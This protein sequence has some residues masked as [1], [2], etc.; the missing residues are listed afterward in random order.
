MATTVDRPTIT[1]LDQPCCTPP[2]TPTVTEPEAETYAAWFKAL[3]NRSTGIV[4]AGAGAATELI[5]VLL[6]A[7]ADRKKFPW[8]AA[9]PVRTMFPTYA[10]CVLTT[11]RGHTMWCS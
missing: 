9:S 8:P 3:A 1:I 5:T 11:R 4:S 10:W 6:R 7:P 2:R